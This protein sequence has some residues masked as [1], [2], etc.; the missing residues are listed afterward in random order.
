MNVKLK[1]IRP[2]GESGPI[3]KKVVPMLDR[4]VNDSPQNVRTQ[5]LYMIRTFPPEFAVEQFAEQLRNL[6][7]RETIVANERRGRVTEGEW[8]AR[9]ILDNLPNYGP[10]SKKALPVLRN[11][12]EDYP[13]L[14]PILG[15][16]LRK[17]IKAIEKPAE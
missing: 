2:E 8:V 12:Q 1:R 11:I 5:A 17:A 14:Q 3:L 4:L 16:R 9:F 15:S 7:A 10:S 13:E 6:V